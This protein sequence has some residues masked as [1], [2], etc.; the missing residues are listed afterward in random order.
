[1]SVSSFWEAGIQHDAKTSGYPA[2][3]GYDYLIWTAMMSGIDLATIKDILGHS[4]IEMTMKYP[5]LSPKH[6]AQAME[7][8]G[9]KL[10]NK[11][12]IL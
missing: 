5:H 11:S 9:G 4:T 3:A 6:K 12:D 7:V 10:E 8:L 2:F 1:M